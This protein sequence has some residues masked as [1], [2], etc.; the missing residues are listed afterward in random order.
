MKKRAYMQSLTSQLLASGNVDVAR[1]VHRAGDVR[2]ILH[3]L[4]GRA[5][6]SDLDPAAGR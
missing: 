2:C 4:L 1:E 3:C 5:C 6:R